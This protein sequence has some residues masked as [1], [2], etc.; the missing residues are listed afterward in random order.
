[1]CQLLSSF[2]VVLFFMLRGESTVKTTVTERDYTYRHAFSTVNGKMRS[3]IFRCKQH[4]HFIRYKHWFIPNRVFYTYGVEMINIDGTDF[5]DYH[6]AH[7]PHIG[8][9]FLA[10]T[11][12][13]H[14]CAVNAHIDTL[15]HHNAV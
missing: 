10:N 4:R 11:T 9:C 1:M 15:N 2:F 12:Y 8:F 13:P 3:I 7:Y 6:V 5:V 14:R